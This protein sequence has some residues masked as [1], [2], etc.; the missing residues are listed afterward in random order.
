ML[1]SRT[2][3]D[4][5]K[6]V[7]EFLRPARPVPAPS[8]QRS[9]R[10]PLPENSIQ[11]TY[12]RITR[13]MLAEHGIRVRRWRTSMSG[14]A[15]QLR[16]AD[17][18]VSRLIESPRP[19]GPMSA[20]IFLHEVG[21]HVIGFDRYKPRCLEEC[22]AWMWSLGAMN[23]LGLNVTDAVKR[24]VHESLWYAVDKA[25]RRG[26][27]TIPPE[28]HPYTTPPARRRRRLASLFS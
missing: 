7:G 26:L 28:L 14:I 17:G 6:P 25:A 11:H 9:R 23:R 8:R 21:H 27:R 3:W 12:D 15:W 18:S 20:A 2:L 13:Q 24:R 1:T 19:R 16:Y 4:L 22:H 5:L 10:S